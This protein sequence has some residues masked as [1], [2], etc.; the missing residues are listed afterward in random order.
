MFN[1]RLPLLLRAHVSVTSSCTTPFPG[2][3]IFMFSVYWRDGWLDYTLSRLWR[4][5]HGGFTLL[6]ANYQ[7][8][9][10]AA[11]VIIVQTE[12]DLFTT[13]TTQSARK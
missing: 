11:L 8:I 10:A 4:G 5:V 2:L 7:L 1:C 9:A 13:S 12:S 6:V 3:F